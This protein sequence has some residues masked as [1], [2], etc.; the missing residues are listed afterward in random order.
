VEAAEVLRATGAGTF[1]AHAR[2]HAARRLAAQGRRSD[3]EAQLASA[4]AFYRGVRAT[5]YVAE[6]EALLAAAS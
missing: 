4:L 1:E 5:W 6:G 3:A 2:W